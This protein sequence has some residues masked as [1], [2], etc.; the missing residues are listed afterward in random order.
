[1]RARVEQLRRLTSARGQAASHGQSGDPAVA[2]PLRRGLREGLEPG[3]LFVAVRAFKAASTKRINQHC[4]SPGAAV[5]QRGYYERV[6]RNERELC[7]VR[8]YI[9]DNP[10]L[11]AEDKHNPAV[12]KYDQ[13]GA[14][15]T[16]KRPRG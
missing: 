3:S 11:W 9:R 4:G 13:S 14:A 1:M 7:A 8:Q 2:Q 16:S 5:W 10:A 15:G 12:F 6:I